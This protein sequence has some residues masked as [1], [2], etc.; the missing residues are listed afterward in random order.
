M[1]GE[2]I[3]RLEPLDTSGVFLG[4]GIV[5]CGLLGSGITLAVVAISAGL[6][7]LVAT[8]PVAVGAGLSFARA[9]GRAAWE[10]LPLAVGWLARSLI[11][12]ERGLAPLPLWP[13]DADAAPPLPPC[14]AGLSLHD[15]PWHDG[16]L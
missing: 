2:R 11:W 4:L 5:Q 3:Y 10:W 14:L 8:L 1:T 12:G 16:T 9:G 15:I 13:T 7:L 6:P